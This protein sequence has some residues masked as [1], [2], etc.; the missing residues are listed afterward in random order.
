MPIRFRAQK[1]DNAYRQ[2]PGEA[3]RTV[4]RYLEING[5]C[6]TRYGNIIAFSLA[7]TTP[8][9]LPGG[10]PSYTLSS[11]SLCHIA[12]RHAEHRMWIPYKNEGKPAT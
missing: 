7:Q 5:M 4:R 1:Y 12:L 3:N 11:L 6:L 10:L 9:F 8:S 2:L